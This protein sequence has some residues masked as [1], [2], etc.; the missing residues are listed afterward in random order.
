[1]HQLEKDLIWFKTYA[2]DFAWHWAKTFEGGAEHSY[3][4][5]GKHLDDESYERAFRVV[6]AFGEP[7][8][9]YRRTNVELVLPD[10]EILFG[11]PGKQALVK[12]IKFWHM[13]ER[14]SVSKAFNMAPMT[15]TYGVQDAPH[16]HSPIK[17]ARDWQAATLIDRREETHALSEKRMNALW[18]LVQ[19][20]GR[21]LDLGPRGGSTLDALRVRKDSSKYTAV[22]PSQ[23]E[24]NVMVWRHPWVHDIWPVLPGQFVHPGRPGHDMR[25][26]RIVALLGEAS[27]LAPEDLLHL[28]TM[29]NPGGRLVLMHYLN[30]PYD[31]YFGE[32]ELP[33]YA[34]ESRETARAL[35]RAK[36]WN[37][38]GY[39][40]T[41]VEN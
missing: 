23:G 32:T 33:P 10:V 15:Y 4:M 20:D 36:S 8:K 40:I 12:G 25:F 1:M 2:P 24:L 29:L 34:A 17:T 6:Q 3:V 31:D 30:D 37:A 21:I 39:M 11:A 22:S 27:Y 28:P 16:T 13:S 19:P 38:G 18:R 14:L 7:A 41:T 35:P 26:D 5:K 9:F